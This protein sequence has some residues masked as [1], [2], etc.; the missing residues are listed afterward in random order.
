MKTPVE[1]DPEE[2]KQ[3]LQHE[4]HISS[5]QKCKHDIEILQKEESKYLSD[6][7]EED[8]NEQENL[9]DIFQ[10]PLAKNQVSL[11]H[12]LKSLYTKVNSIGRQIRKLKK[13]DDH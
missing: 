8:E 6:E 2:L 5:L 4:E 3:V 11:S 1:L 10:V 13:A 7:D 12:I 9:E